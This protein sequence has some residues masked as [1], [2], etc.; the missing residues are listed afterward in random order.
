MGP[1]APFSRGWAYPAVALW[2]GADMFCIANLISL[3]GPFGRRPL[4][5][6]GI[7]YPRRGAHPR[8]GGTAG[9]PSGARVP[10]NLMTPCSA[11]TKCRKLFL[12]HFSQGAAAWDLD[13]HDPNGALNGYI[14]AHIGRNALLSHLLSRFPEYGLGDTQYQKRMDAQSGMKMGVRSVPKF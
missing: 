6:T 2:F 10:A 4:W 12:S 3:S 9:P 13:Y 7:P 11:G 1:L 14:R 8:N 5:R